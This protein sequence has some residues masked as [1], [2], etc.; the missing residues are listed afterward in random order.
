MASSVRLSTRTTL[1]PGVRLCDCAVSVVEFVRKLS[2]F[3][4]ALSDLL[5]E[6]RDLCPRANGTSAFIGVHFK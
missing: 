5:F 6:H 4:D 3:E 2:S 1:L